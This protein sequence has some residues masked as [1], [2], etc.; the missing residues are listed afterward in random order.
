MAA[1]YATLVQGMSIQARDGASKKQLL[2][3][4]EAALAA[5]DGMAGKK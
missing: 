1:F 3:T 5:W 4:V 2:A